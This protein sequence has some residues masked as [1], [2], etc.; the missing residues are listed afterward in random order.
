M[1]GVDRYYED[2]RL[3]TADRYET[4]REMVR[5]RLAASMLPADTRTLLDVGSGNGAFLRLIEETTSMTTAGVEPSAAART[6]SVCRTAVVDASAENLPF[7]DDSFD[8]VC[9][10]E[11]IEH[12]RQGLYEQ[13]LAQMRRV[14]RRNVL[15]S[16]PY[17]E[18]EEQVRCP[19]CGCQFH[20]HYHMRRF[21]DQT[22][23]GLLLPMRLVRRDLIDG[24]DYLG[25]RTL[26]RLYGMVARPTAFP[27]LVVCPQCGLSGND[28]RSA[29]PL[30]ARAR[31]GL[32]RGF[33]GRLPKVRRPKW[34]LALYELD[35][36]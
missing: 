35:R 22:M 23:E 36:A 14:A 12:L 3:W 8:V 17:R 11:V 26:R 13:A 29:M 6:S 27:P 25:G 7:G 32:A 18:A 34:I 15:I 5:F 19:G 33:R 2:P 10:L 24:E 21:D 1:T 31:E 9:A 28:D 20:P 16:V 30:A 4:E